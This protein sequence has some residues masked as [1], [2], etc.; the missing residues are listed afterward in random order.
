M[1][2]SLFLIT[3]AAVFIHLLCSSA[4]AQSSDTFVFTHVNVIPMTTQKVLMDQNVV[5]EAGRIR[6]IGP[7]SEVQPPGGALVIDG[8]GRFLI[9]GLT[10]MHVH[11]E[12]DAWNIMYPAGKGFTASEIDFEDI[13]FIYVANGITTIDVLFAFPEHLPLREKI[14]NDEVLGPRLILSRMIDGAGKAWPPPLGVWI[15]NP[16]EAEQAVLEAHRQGYDRIKV[17]SF[18][19]RE[20]YD[21]IM[22]T[23]RSIRMPVDGHI[24]FATSVEHVVSSG[25]N[26][27]AHIEEVVK[28]APTYDSGQVAYFSDLLAGSSTWVTS[29]LVLNRNLNDLLQDSAG[30]FSKPNTEYLHPMAMGIWEYVY[31]N[32]YKP[33]PEKHRRAMIEGYRRFQKPFAYEF[34]RKGGKLLIGT[35]ALVP[36]TQPGFS[37]HEEL[38]ELVNAGL[39]PFDALKVATRNTHEFL[40]E[41]GNAGTIEAGKTADLVLLDENP[42]EDIANTR[43]IRGVMIRG[44]WVPRD[45]IDRQLGE[46]KSSFAELKRKRPH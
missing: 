3:L 5:V 7:S 20:S 1:N 43:S 35:D 27:I 40:G 10:D 19:D 24:P 37:L 6:H 14:N 36:S 2:R 31:Q 22:A 4:M 18:L 33:I 15:N 11:L 30:Q 41:S 12:G 23:A 8:R 45:E 42:L 32:I 39:T 28:F 9:P 17:Y 21:R 29:A 34:H 26:M 38:E 46:I 13:L 44:R 25:Q 16:D